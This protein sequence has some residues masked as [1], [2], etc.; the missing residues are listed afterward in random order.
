MPHYKLSDLSA[1]LRSRVEGLL[2]SKPG[3]SKYCAKRCEVDGEKF[4]SK[5]ERDRWLALRAMEQAGEISR[6]RR[7]VVYPLL[8]QGVQIGKY[9]AD[10]VY[11]RDGL[12]V[13]EDAKGVLPALGAWKLKHMAAQGTPVELWPPRKAKRRKSPRI[14]P[15]A[16][17]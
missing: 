12:E 3:S 2:P 6:M 10:F 7:Q 16:S 11:L 8:V 13:I 1:P 4:D 14:A 9:I 5:L 17:T 15:R